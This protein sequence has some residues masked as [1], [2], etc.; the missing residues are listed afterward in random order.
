MRL[1]GSW[2]GM[3]TGWQPGFRKVMWLLPLPGPLIVSHSISIC[4]EDLPY[5]IEAHVLI[6]GFNPLKEFVKLGHTAPPL[7]TIINGV[8]YDVKALGK[9]YQ[10]VQRKE[11]KHADQM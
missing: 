7:P 3:V 6:Q 8:I 4:F 11:T 5:F 9:N 1:I 10:K 2:T